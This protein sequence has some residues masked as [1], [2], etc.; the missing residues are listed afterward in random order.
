MII[1][2]V[3]KCHVIIDVV[4]FIQFADNYSNLIGRLCGN[5]ITACTSAQAALES[6]A[7]CINAIAGNSDATMLC[8]KHAGSY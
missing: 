7:I 5:G 1:H 6:N 3:S 2:Y 4:N 8:A